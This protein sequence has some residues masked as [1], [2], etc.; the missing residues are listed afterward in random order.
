MPEN[1]T[2][3]HVKFDP[4]LVFQFVSEI[5]YIKYREKKKRKIFGFR[6]NRIT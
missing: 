4:Y 2:K 3:Y 1:K 5:Y 6:D